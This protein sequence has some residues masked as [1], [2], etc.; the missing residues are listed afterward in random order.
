MD[1]DTFITRNVSCSINSSINY[2]EILKGLNLPPKEWQIG[3]TKVFLRQKVYEPL[4]DRR[5]TTIQAAAVRIQ[6]LMRMNK[7]RKGMCVLHKYTSVF[8]FYYFKHT[9]LRA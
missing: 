2:S 9:Q 6:A 7:H 1:D 3:K 8:Y 5:Y 4:E